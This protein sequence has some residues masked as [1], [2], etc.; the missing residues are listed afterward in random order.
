MGCYGDARI[1]PDNHVVRP[2]LQED[3]EASLQPFA[4]QNIQI[5]GHICIKLGS[6]AFAFTGDALL[7][8][9]I[10]PFI[11]VEGFSFRNHKDNRVKHVC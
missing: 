11:K 10:R 1:K 5:I 8:D 2:I 7:A 4:A 3:L 9:E 6:V